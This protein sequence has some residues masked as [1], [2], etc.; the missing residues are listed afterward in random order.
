MVFVH[1]RVTPNARRTTFLTAPTGT[2]LFFPDYYCEVRGLPLHSRCGARPTGRNT[3]G[4]ARQITLGII[5]QQLYVCVCV[6]NSRACFMTLPDGTVHRNVNTPARVGPN[7]SPM[8]DG[9]WLD[10][11]NL[12]LVDEQIKN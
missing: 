1:T 10:T 11:R 2:G 9:N 12:T 5:K 3:S 7:F 4:A 8:P 6:Q